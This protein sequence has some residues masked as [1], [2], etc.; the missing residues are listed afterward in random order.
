MQD[1]LRGLKEM[2][3]L[4]K[5]CG[6]CEEGFAERF[7]F[8]PDCGASL[9][10]F[11]M[12]P[13]TNEIKLQEETPETPAE[14]VAAAQFASADAVE[15][16]PV[17]QVAAPAE[18]N[19]DIP[20][21]ADGYDASTGPLDA[22]YVEAEIIEPEDSHEEAAPVA[23]A[24]IPAYY[25]AAEMHADEPRN[26]WGVVADG[27][28]DDGGYHV[29]VIQEKNV[30][31]RNVLL[32]GSTVLMVVLAVGGTILSLFNKTLGIDAIGDE[33]SLAYLIDDVPMV[34][35][36]EP[37]KKKE[38]DGGGGGGGG[39][40]EPDPVSQGDLPDQT[41][42]PIR[43]PDVNTYRSDNFE[44]KT[45]VPST[46]SDRKFEKKYDRWGDPNSRFAGLSNGPGTGGGMGTGVG[47]GVGSGRGTGVGSGT[48][49][50][51]GSGNGD[52]DGDGTG[53]GRG[54]G[55]PPPPVKPAVTTAMRFISKPRANYTD[56]ARTN[57]VTGSVKLK[58]TL[59]A[60]GQV[61]S[62]TAVTRL[63]HGLTE[64]AIAAARLIRFE[65][66]RVNGVPVSTIA[67]VEY[68]FNIY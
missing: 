38:D 57:A 10:T 64:Q 62:I 65:P 15:E 30:K 59:L 4:V 35:E 12:N 50:G 40:D 39:K 44:L 54:T 66:R 14:A 13:I 63:P 5:Y 23:A 20:V 16:A 37:E 11:E 29:T 33:R 58:V 36:E 18:I 8:C 6:S 67:T 31:Q 49:S 43:P 7:A 48:G 28:D 21:Y 46:E 41:R 56:A 9:Q 2:G 34:V 22:D 53:S 27:S 1:S 61:G 25:H 19:E 47:T 32:L 26:A 45:P 68:N 42:E 3:K 55:A 17:E 60:S 51:S 52:G 24:T